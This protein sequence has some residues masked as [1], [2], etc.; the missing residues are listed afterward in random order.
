M[1]VRKLVIVG[2]VAGGEGANA[3]LSEEKEERGRV[4]MSRN[5]PALFVTVLA[6]LVLTGYS[7]ENPVY[8]WSFDDTKELE[9]P[10][11]VE[12]KG[13]IIIPGSTR[14]EVSGV[15]YDIRGLAKYTTGVSG[16]AI[17]FD[18]FS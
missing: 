16:S 18:G 1:K 10:W 2:G 5:W 6:V 17:K 7:N 4:N 8:Y 3:A 12:G 13:E 11:G 14:E 9:I 15:D